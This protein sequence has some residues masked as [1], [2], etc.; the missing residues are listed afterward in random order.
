MAKI[1]RL[2]S[3]TSIKV[4]PLS[5]VLPDGTIVNPLPYEG[6]NITFDD[7]VR[8]QVERPLNATKVSDAYQEAKWVKATTIDGIS[9]NQ[10]IV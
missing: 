6:V 4:G 1:I 2:E 8:V 5:T 10:I 3:V 7:G 9:T